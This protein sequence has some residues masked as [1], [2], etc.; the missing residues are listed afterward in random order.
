VS[1]GSLY[2]YF[3]NK[4]AVAEA[5]RQRHFGNILSV[6]RAAADQTTQRSSRIVTLIDGM[7]SAHSLDP[8]A[9]RVLSEECPRG[10]DAQLTQDSFETEWRKG[11]EE[12]Y[13]A[14]ANCDRDHVCVGAALLAGAVVGS[15]HEAARRGI[16]N[17]PDVRE[18]LFAV[19]EA[20]L[21]TR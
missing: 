5:V 20:Y 13:A 14:N 7:I 17:R 3:P 16:L 21:S 18:Q 8:A 9:W 12:V 6:L 19:V 10:A 15:V 11:Y 1:I 2:Q 4:V